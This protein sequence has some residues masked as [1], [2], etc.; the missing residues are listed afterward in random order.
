M[1]TRREIIK[2]MAPEYQKATK[3]EKRKILDELVHLTGYTRTYASWLLSHHG[4]KVYLTGQDG[5]K[6]RVIGSITKV[7]RNRKKIYDEEVLASLKKIW[8][9]FDC[10]CGKR[11]APSL[12][13]MI[14]KLEKH[15]ELALSQ[16]VR[17]KLLAISPA[18]V[19]G[20]SKRK[21]ESSPPS[22][23]PTLNPGL[24]LN[25]RF[26]FVPLP[27]GMRKDQDSVKLI[28]LPTMAETPGGISAK[29]LM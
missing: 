26:Q 13:W 28:W 18:T 24:S 9:I 1:N 6:Y 25:T 27:I 22:P 17:R 7:K 19:L 21:N 10:P 12:P 3:K 16:E 8:L 14:K 11:L 4:R 23:G 29:L 20:F 2:K 15:E 5:K